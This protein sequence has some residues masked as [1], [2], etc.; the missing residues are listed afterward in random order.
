MLQREHGGINRLSQLELIHSETGKHNPKDLSVAGP[1]NN[2]HG[3][4]KKN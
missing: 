2:I 1:K 3:S 4:N